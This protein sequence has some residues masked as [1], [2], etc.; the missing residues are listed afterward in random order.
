MFNLIKRLPTYF[1]FSDLEIEIEGVRYTIP[2]IPNDGEVT[3]PIPMDLVGDF[4]YIIWRVNTD[5]IHGIFT[6]EA[7]QETI[8]LD[9]CPE[10]PPPTPTPTPETTPKRV[11]TKEMEIEQFDPYRMQL[12]K[13]RQTVS[14]PSWCDGSICIGTDHC[15]R[16][17]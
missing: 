10:Q 7:G 11:K 12:L 5:I 4:E 15:G 16:F 1:G 8:D 6:R 13:E 17:Y 2:T 3:I 9:A 14:Q